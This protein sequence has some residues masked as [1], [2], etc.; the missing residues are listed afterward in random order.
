MAAGVNFMETPL[1]LW[2][3]TFSNGRTL[4]FKDL[5][6]GVFLNDVMLQID[7]R[8]INYQNVNRAVEDVNI[9]LHNW[10]ILIRN[11]RAYYVDVLQQL[12]ILK[13]PNYQTICREPD[14]D[15][16]LSEMRKTLLLILGCAVQ[17]E[18]KEYF[19]DKIKQLDVDVQTAIVEHI[20]EITDDSE[21]IL[22]IEPMEQLETYAE[23][24]FK[25]LTRVIKER[26]DFSEVSVELAQERDFFQTQLQ[27][28]IQGTTV[29]VTPPASPEK[30]HLVVELADS[31]AKV[32]R[33]RQDLEDKQEIL[34][35]MRDE[36]EENK[37]LVARLRNENSEL[38]QDA[39]AARSLRDELD[40]L[41]EKL[42]KADS[43]QNEILKYKEKLNELE[44]YKTRVDELREDNT[45]LI[46]TKNLLEEQLSNC[47]KRVETVV[48]LENELRKK[49]QMVE[50]MALERDSDREKLRILTEENAQLQYE[51]KSSLNES[52]NLE[53]ELDS[54]RLRIMG[55]GGSL[56]DQLTETTNA[57]ILRL[58]LE[59]QRLNQ[60]LEEA[61][62]K[63]LIE[64]A[65]RN[66]ELEKENQRLAK[67]VEKLLESGQETSQNCLELE[68][69]MEQLQIEKENLL[70]TLE[71]VK[72]N[73]ERQVKELEREKEQLSHTV[74]VVRARSEQTNDAR[75]KD[76]ERENKRMSHSVSQKDQQLSKLEFENRQLQKSYNSLK[77]NCD[78]ISGLE[79]ENANLEKENNEMHKMISTLKLTCDKYETLE[80]ENSD[81]DVENRKLQKSVK[82]LN[83]QLQKKEI[84]EQDVINLRVEN[85]KLQRSLDALKNSSQRIAEVENEKDSLNRELQHLK[86]TLEVQKNLRT[87]QEQ[88][89]LDLLDLDNENQ[90]VQ[91]SLEITTKRV[92]QLEKDNSDLEMENEKLQKT[93]EKMKISNKRLHET[94]KQVSELEEEVRKINKEKSALEKENKRV[95]QTLDLKESAFDDISAKHSALNRELK[96]LKKSVESQKDTT[97]HVRELEKENREVKQ[98]CAMHQRTVATL[99]EDLVN[100]KI[101]S[102]NLTNDFDKLTQELE[103]VGI[104]KEKLVMTDHRQD[105]NRYKALE[106]MMEEALKKSMEIKE[107][108]IH[109]LESRLEESK[110]RNL[111]LQEELRI[112]KRECESL[113]QRYEEESHGRD[114]E[115][116]ETAGLLRGPPTY[117]RSNSQSTTKE[118]LELKDHLVQVER[119]NA[120]MMAENKNM[121]SQ[122]NALNEQ[123][124]KL[125]NQNV[126]LQSE[127]SSLQHQ[128][129]SMQSDNAKLQ[130]ENST[131]KSHCSS[132]QNQISSLQSHMNQLETEHQHLIQTHEELQ[133][134]H[135]E[136]VQDHEELQRI[137]EQLTSEYEG[138]I[139]EHGSLKSVHKAIKNENKELHEQLSRSVQGKDQLNQ[140]QLELKSMRKLQEENALLRDEHERMAGQ[141]EKLRTDYRDLLADHK[142][143]KNE[144]NQAQ[145][146]NTDLQ[147][148][149]GEMKDQLHTMELEISGLGHKYDTLY[150][151]NQK[152]EEDNKNL[153]MQIQTL[154]NS[155]QDLLS[156]ILDSKEH[157]NEEEKSYLE[158]MNDLKRQKERLEEKIMEHYKRQDNQKK[159]RGLG[160]RIARKAARIFATKHPRS[161]SRT[162]LA[163][164]TGDNSLLGDTTDGRSEL[165]SSRP[166]S[167][168]N[169]T[170]EPSLAKQNTSLAKSAGTLNQSDKITESYS[171][172]GAKSAEDLL[173]DSTRSNHDKESF[174]SSNSTNL[175]PGL[176]HP[177]VLG[178]DDDDDGG[179]GSVVQPNEMMTLEEFL[180]EANKGSPKTGKSAESR[181]QEDTESKSSENS[182][183][184]GKRNFRKRQAPAPPLQL[185]TPPQSGSNPRIFSSIPDVAAVSS[186]LDLSRMSRIS[187]GSSGS[188]HDSRPDEHSTPP[189]SIR[190]HPE[191][192]TPA[193]SSASNRLNNGSF[194]DLNQCSPLTGDPRRFT[195]SSTPSSASRTLQYSFGNS[196][197]AQSHSVQSPQSRELPPT[198]ANTSDRITASDRL[199]R[200]VSSNLQS[201]SPQ[202]NYDP[203]VRSGSGQDRSGQNL[204]DKPPLARGFTP[205]GPHN[206]PQNF[207]NSGK[208]GP[209]P[210]TQYRP[211]QN[212]YSSYPGP[213]QNGPYQ[214]S[215][216]YSETVKNP[217]NSE[218]NRRLSMHEASSQQNI[219][220]SIDDTRSRGYSSSQTNLN[221]SGNLN[222][223]NSANITNGPFR[224]PSSE[225]SH[226]ARIQRIERPKSVPP[227][228]VNQ[229]SPTKNTSDNMYSQ[230]N[231]TPP[232]PPPRRLKDSTTATRLLREPSQGHMSSQ[233]RHIIAS[234][235]STP[236]SGNS[237]QLPQGGI[238]RSHTSM[239]VR[240][241]PPA[242]QVNTPPPPKVMNN[243]PKDPKEKNSVCR[244]TR[245]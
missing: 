231:K 155:N 65:E 3:E 224:N 52:T 149:C 228:V 80:Q 113:K 204:S 150:Q 78:R 146:R 99:R 107:E 98:Q 208:L 116:R 174:S 172:R 20:K 25:H 123:I 117:V 142:K 82:S 192:S 131:L 57:K 39:R 75:L 36:L 187:G 87:K 102:Q 121:K 81:L 214:S 148:Q 49:R 85:Q 170:D 5:C 183:N 211:Q 76:L 163:E 240:I 140:M 161:K 69:E 241:G 124:K 127:N 173:A 133:S 220:S 206:R 31:K 104:N 177:A 95:K 106:S 108:K 110:N 94:E 15:I 158:K 235:N 37:S 101:K 74:E 238:T 54:A 19:I 223:H 100:E 56:S 122:T 212:S 202:N 207:H 210:N 137:H 119:T 176:G 178:D 96:S 7:P 58:E 105:E 120:T 203:S 154:L 2:V 46:E 89:E 90:R 236:P 239:G 86:K 66:L 162:N 53:K 67:K 4:E 59:N 73:S 222:N 193:V 27:C 6:D 18:R 77:H 125:E 175:L 185:S 226:Y 169:I 147:G 93:I 216:G 198:P 227:G 153:L 209:S 143:V 179:F 201:S 111:K 186:H 35:D 23:K 132:L 189:H 200:L 11:V 167:M 41:R 13:L 196:P 14:K 159:N 88:M 50:E 30:H 42:G 194:E 34:S 60:K 190:G 168:W 12:L 244:G 139:S 22:P 62:E 21:S 215:P 10:E 126:R 16:S 141:Y 237:R 219:Y 61:R 71:T 195:A 79:N 33:L 29:P 109:A 9:Q 197:Q 171:S 152:M 26:D 233:G 181:S 180:N 205:Q 48:E 182:D 70:Q 97:T 129:H 184:S 243:E 32:R 72:E 232:V 230:P 47:H 63:M 218:S 51:K 157:F 115:R 1:V 164:T 234:R 38:I 40:V 112:L 118:I 151:V 128:G 136:L 145:L 188:G 156:Q 165:R 217:S 229:Q 64:N 135:E 138:L 92:Q 91:K 191:T 221:N 114:T 44:F 103:K 225:E 83:D 68:Q 84:L 43:F 28:S 245:C 166:V 199:D 8:P 24:M 55:A 213:T 144:L 242:K 134:S 160:A 17:C 130:V 45:I